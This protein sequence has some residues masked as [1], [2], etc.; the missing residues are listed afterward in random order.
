MLLDILQDKGALFYDALQTRSGFLK[1]QLDEALGELVALGLTS[2]DLFSGLTRLFSKP[3]SRHK[4]SVTPLP[5]GRW[6]IIQPNSIPE[7]SSSMESDA[8]LTYLV[9]SLLRR[10]GIIFKSLLSRETCHNK[11]QQLLPFLQRMEWSGEIRS[12]RFV[13]GQ[14]GQQFALPEAVQQLNKTRAAAGNQETIIINATDP[15]NLI[16]ILTPD[17]KISA[18]PNSRILFQQGR[19]IAYLT[20]KDVIFLENIAQ[21]KHWEIKNRLIRNTDIVSKQSTLLT[22]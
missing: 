20:G 14:Y 18:H 13:S 11:W 1:S 3:V 10:Y 17:D 7:E 8:A 12:G 22:T 6:N 19:A 2:C 21:E 16:G 4:K 9:R 5:G 15:L